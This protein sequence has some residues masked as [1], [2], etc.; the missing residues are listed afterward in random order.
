MKEHNFSTESLIGGWYMPESICDDMINYFDNNSNKHFKTNTII[1]KKDIV[2]D[3]R[4]P[5]DKF[6]KPQPFQ[7]YCKQLDKC[8]EQY[9]NKYE[10]SRKSPKI[11]LS[12]FHY[13]WLLLKHHLQYVFRYSKNL[14]EYLQPC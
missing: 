14:C 5:L 11:F 2:D 13:H 12:V 7:K 8:L 4:I 10:Y 3:T 1:G 9:K 6:N